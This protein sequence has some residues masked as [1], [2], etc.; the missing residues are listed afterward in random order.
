MQTILDWINW[1]MSFKQYQAVSFLSR[2]ALQ[3]Y[4]DLV[5][6]S[7]SNC[8]GR[9][10]KYGARA[11][12]SKIYTTSLKVIYCEGWNFSIAICVLVD[13]TMQSGWSV[14]NIWKKYQKEVVTKDL[15]YSL[16]HTTLCMAVFRLQSVFELY[17]NMLLVCS[18]LTHLIPWALSLFGMSHAVYILAVCFGSVCFFLLFLKRN[19]LSFFVCRFSDAKRVDMDGAPE[20]EWCWMHIFCWQSGQAAC[21]DHGQA[22]QA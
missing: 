18:C 6:L 21:F 16:K 13:E 2:S 12:I 5:N 22:D 7:Q 15:W 3:L 19:A 4:L 8:W 10:R 1:N 17:T 14:E 20:F 11:T 9:S